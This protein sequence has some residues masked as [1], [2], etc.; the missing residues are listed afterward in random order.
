MNIFPL[1]FNLDYWLF[2]L[3]LY[4]TI[5]VILIFILLFLYLYYSSKPKTHTQ[6]QILATPPL[7]S[8]FILNLLSL[9][10]FY[11][12]TI[13]YLPIIGK[14]LPDYIFILFFIGLLVQVF[15]CNYS[16]NTYLH[17]GYAHVPCFQTP[18]I[19]HVVFAILT[20]LFF[21][22]MSLFLAYF[23]FQV[24]IKTNNLLSRYK[25]II[26]FFNNY[27]KDSSAEFWE[28][29]VYS[30]L[31]SAFIFL[32]T[33]FCWALS[34]FQVVAFSLLFFFYTHSFRFNSQIANRVRTS[35]IIFF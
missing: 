6:F 29:V 33:T 35:Q 8:P 31:L 19:I 25:L 24:R 7:F 11:F 30:I 1:V 9:F 12:I 34:L 2:I 17:S 15:N 5:A 18:H 27:R 26:S 20:L 28:L 23:L 13:L 3:I 32:K 22:P 21:I 4:I 10:S 16:S 14:H